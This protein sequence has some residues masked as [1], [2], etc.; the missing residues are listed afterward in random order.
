MPT[1]AKIKKQP[2]SFKYRHWLSLGL[3]FAVLIILPITIIALQKARFETRKGAAPATVLSLE[4]A[5]TTIAPNQPFDVNVHINS[6]ANQIIAVDLVL[7]YN[8]AI[9]KVNNITAGSFLVNPQQINKTIDNGAGKVIYSIYTP[10]RTD[11]KSGEGTL[12]IINFEGISTGTSGV[13]FDPQTGIGALGESESALSQTIPGSYTISTIP[14]SPTPGPSGSPTPSP[15]PNSNPPVCGQSTIPPNTGYAPL[16]VSLHGAGGSGSGPGFDGYRWDFEGDGVWDTNVLLDPVTHIYNQPG[17]YHPKYQVHGVNNVWSAVCDYPYTIVVQVPP[18]PSPSPSP[19]PSPIQPILRFKIKFNGVTIRPSDD[20][21]KPVQYYATSL[22]GGPDLA[23]DTNKG[24]V[25]VIVDDSG[26]Y[27]G[28]ITLSSS[29]FL[30]HHYRL[31][32]KGPKHLQEVFANVVF[33]QKVEL[34]LTSRPLRPGD[35][36]QDGKLDAADMT[37][38]NDRIFATDPIEIAKVDVNYDNEADMFDR[39]EIFD[40]LSVQYDLE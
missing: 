4:P 6:G 27:H 15:S 2:L 21:A 13:I 33:Q 40:T 11:A 3:V 14:A 8:P 24:V 34:D 17:N 7:T 12:A 38:I 16:T 37:L 5:T 1:T 39:K 32:L 22:D 29:N 18:T 28:S 23:S 26:V 35:L 31:R 30:N 10:N 36:N 9:L 25:D 20:S 19:S